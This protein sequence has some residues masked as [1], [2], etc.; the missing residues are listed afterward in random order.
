MDLKTRNIRI[1]PEHWEELLD[2][3]S[4]GCMSTSHDWEVKDDYKDKVCEPII[5][6]PLAPRQALS[7]L[8]VYGVLASY[9]IRINDITEAIF[10]EL[11]VQ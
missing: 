2:V 6:Y 4:K 5:H 10:R 11:G 8:K 9:G 1:S 3:I 7:I